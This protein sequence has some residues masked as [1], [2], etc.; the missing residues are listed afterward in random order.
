MAL[1]FRV[2][3]KLGGLRAA[4]PHDAEIMATLPA[5]QP[6][7]VTAVANPRGAKFHNWFFGLLGV[8]A[9]ATDRPAKEVLTIIKIGVGHTED[10]IMPHTGEIVR[11]P[12]SI[13]WAQM[14]GP[15]FREFVDLAIKFIIEHMM[16][17]TTNKELE[18]EVWIRLGI[19]L[20]QV[21]EPR[22]AR[23]ITGR[24]A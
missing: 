2:I 14:D 20:D 11:I 19:S 3:R 22:P 23:R 15:Q 24:A 7:K 8:V 16:P 6:I 12:R 4:S 10:F 17:G 18:E 1:E 5:D 21:S 9:E 13:S